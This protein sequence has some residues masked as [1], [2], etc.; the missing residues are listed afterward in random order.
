MNAALL[1][2]IIIGV[3]AAHLALLM[4][5]SHLR[6]T[7]PLPPAP[8]P[9]NF[10]ARSEVL[11]DAKTGEKTT[12]REITVSTRLAERAGLQEGKQ[13]PAVPPHAQAGRP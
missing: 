6:P 11:L 12:V 8:P 10:S 2:C 4:L 3:L 1:G 13:A 7:S 5:L 9:P